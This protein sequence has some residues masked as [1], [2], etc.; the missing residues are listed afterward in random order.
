MVFGLTGILY[1][2]SYSLLS[3]VRGPILFNNRN[4]SLFFAKLHLRISKKH[5]LAFYGREWTKRMMS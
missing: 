5:D 4:F 1:T 2:L 3:T